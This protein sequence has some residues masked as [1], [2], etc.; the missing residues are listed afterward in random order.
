LPPPPKPQP[1]S[2]QRLLRLLARLD[3]V[4]IALI[5]L[6]AYLVASFPAYNSDL[7]M[8]LASGR[9]LAQGQYQLG[10][11]P[12]AFTTQGVYWVN[13]SWLYDLLTYWLF[14]LPTIGGALLV[15]L[16][17]LLVMALAEVM[18][19]TARNPGQSLWIP[20]SS[21]GLAVLALSP[22]LFLQP[23]CLSYF[24]LGLTLWLLRRPRQRAVGATPSF[25]GFWMIPLLCLLWVNLDDWFFL[26]P[27]TV[28][29]YLL[30]EFLQDT[31][32]PQTRGTDAPAP[33]ELRTLTQVF[34]VSLLA[35]L[36]NPHHIYAFTLPS[37]LGL[38]G[39]GETL[40][41][42]SQ[43]HFLFISPLDSKD[44]FRK[45]F[46]LSV[47][48]LAYFPLAVLGLI[49]FVLV[50]GASLLADGEGKAKAG[51]PWWR[52]V[53]WLAFFVPTLANSRLIPFFAIV[54]GPIMALNFLDFSARWLD[55]EV[56]LS[57]LARRWSV[58]G[59]VLTILAVLVLLVLTIPGWTQCQPYETRR[60]GWRVEPDASLRQMAL[61]INAWRD[62]HL[63]EADTPWFNSGPEV[64]YYLAWFAPGARGFLDHRLSLYD[65]VA[66]DYL[67]VRKDLT[68]ETEDEEESKAGRQP[69]PRWRS[70]FRE[71]KINFLIY[72]AN[73]ITPRTL[74]PFDM[75]VR[76]SNEWSLC[77]LNGRTAIFAWR[78][79]NRA[80]ES[81]PAARLR[82]NVDQ[83]A[84]SPNTAPA[85]PKRLERVP[86]AHEWWNALWQAEAPRSLDSDALVLYYFHFSS[87]GPNYALR[88]LRA[89]EAAEAASAFG[90]STGPGGPLLNG[91][92]LPLRLTW[93]YKRRY[94]DLSHIPFTFWD[95]IA[96]RQLPA[97]LARNQDAGPPGSLYLAIRAARRAQAANPD[98]PRAFLLLGQA[99]HTLSLLT[100]ERARGEF[101]PEVSL[102][103][104]TQIVAALTQAL[105]LKP[106]NQVAYVAHSMLAE[107]FAKQEYLDLTVKHRIE[108]LRLMKDLG[109]APGEPVEKFQA[110]VG[111]EEQLVKELDDLL[112]KRQEKFEVNAANKPPV[113]RALIAKELG[114]PET[115]VSILLKADP[116][117]LMGSHAEGART[118]FTLLLSMGRLA[119][120]RDGLTLDSKT[121]LGMVILDDPREAAN[122]SQRLQR[123]PMLV[124]AYEWFQSLLAAASGDY[125]EADRYLA[126][127]Q[128]RLGQNPAA[129]QAMRQLNLIGSLPSTEPPND[130]TVAAM[131][132]AQSLLEQAP[133]VAGM[134]RLNL[135]PFYPSPP[136]RVALS[137]AAQLAYYSLEQEADLLAVRGWLNLEAGKIPEAHK[138]FQEALA[139]CFPEGQ[140]EGRYSLP[141]RS[142][143]L[144]EMYLEWLSAYAK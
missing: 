18:L 23:I 67:R 124:P 110:R 69:D 56:S 106:N 1:P 118:A 3:G 131:V 140:K 22:R 11:D 66:D 78:D 134:P 141:L 125:E 71:H 60:V 84:F 70:V 43:F 114:L 132:F 139:L 17:A 77:Y 50:L 27:L 72:H 123:T 34:V 53:V 87:M 61:Q 102:I 29:L 122:R 76:A 109:A 75:L 35:C 93:P 2:P 88:N 52:A 144:V 137:Q 8:H 79:P 115:S 120:A 36:V 20:A 16:K 101:L 80:S 116:E 105:E 91:T 54:A 107:L 32:A 44:Y 130:R 74:L 48:G 82:L 138:R 15:V 4:L 111:K 73:D 113:V 143:L 26:G 127:V 30:G 9:L 39:A 33:G 96:L 59:R 57:A 99:Y 46:G 40:V 103:R 24:F 45:D 136:W 41:K 98:D 100:R 28:G 37:V 58:G 112:R 5:L 62:Q 68:G 126:E 7:F 135:Y 92:L 142:R 119:E 55:S 129:Y 128:T 63:V 121:G 25:R 64:L 89:L 49:S 90:T 10:V 94:E 95:E 97:L 65:K 38:S 47:A 14:L 19:R 85:P 13:H 51:W 108:A 133:Q 117:D 86:E 83:M 21:V 6:F 12:F 81:D 31:F 42:D 104:D